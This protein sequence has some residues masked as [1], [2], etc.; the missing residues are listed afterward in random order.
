MNNMGE[1]AKGWARVTTHLL[2]DSA[3]PIEQ[4]REE[5]KDLGID[6]E[7]A[8]SRINE[9]IRHGIQSRIR[10]NAEA[11]I[12]ERRRLA[13]EWRK[14]IVT[15]PIERVRLLRQQAE[16]GLYGNAGQELAIA[17]RNEDEATSVT[18]E[19]LRAQMVDI[20]VAS[21]ANPDELNA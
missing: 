11:G 4:V 8:T 7:S 1:R 13:E 18:D 14:K 19:E 16:S 10:A 15:L 2:D 21:G 6:V 9:T 20:L 12:E 5:L 3:Y 17:C